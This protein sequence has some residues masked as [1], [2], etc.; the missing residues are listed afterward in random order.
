MNGNDE[1]WPSA[2]TAQVVR[3]MRRA[4]REAGL[5]MGDVASGC[6]ERGLPLPEQ[7]IKNF[8]TGRRA[9]MTLAEFVVLADVLGVPPVTLL[10]P[11]AVDATVDVLPGRPA[12]TWDALAWFTGE[13][14]LDNPAPSGSA[15]ETLDVFRAHA[16]LVNAALASAA[17]AQDR[18]RAASTTLDPNRRKTLLD[19]AAGYEE[20]AFEDSRELAAYRA[21]MRDRGLV[22]PAL[23]DHLAFADPEAAE[24]GS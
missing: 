1:D 2:F 12:P 3:E 22:P 6:S 13:T 23:P 10:Y 8:E 20:H 15:R 9:S 18:R 11:V 24:D 16:D 7:T 14:A 19:R 21:R 5:T 17:L 4:R